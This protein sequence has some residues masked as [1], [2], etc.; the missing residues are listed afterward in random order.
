MKFFIPLLSI[1]LGTIVA[2]TKDADFLETLFIKSDHAELQKF[3]AKKRKS[4]VLEYDSDGK[5]PV[6]VSVLNNDYD[7]LQLLLKHGGKK[8]VLQQDK[9]IGESPL[10]L[11]ACR[12]NTKIVELLLQY[13]GQEAVKQCNNVGTNSLMYACIAGNETIALILLE[14]SDVKILKQKNHENKTAYDY[15]RDYKMYSVIKKMEKILNL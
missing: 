8:A 3:L 14:Y 4:I 11:A 10:M 5:T 7:A 13:G 15:A 12:T 9:N 1:I 6:M 2:T